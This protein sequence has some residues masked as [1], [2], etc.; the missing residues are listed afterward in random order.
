MM[1]KTMSDATVVKADVSMLL[2]RRGWSDLSIAD[3]GLC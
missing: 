2:E 3:F 1:L